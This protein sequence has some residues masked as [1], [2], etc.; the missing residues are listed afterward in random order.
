MDPA[1]AAPPHPPQAPAAPGSPTA[2]E[3]YEHLLRT[4][5]R[6]RTDLASRLGLSG[7]TLTR[8]TREMLD[9]GLLRE[10]PP[11]PQTKGRPQLP[12]DVDEHHALFV[13]LK[14]TATEVHAV[15]VDVRGRSLEELSAPLRDTA[16]A[17]VIP[18]AADL[19][20]ALVDSHPRIAGIGAAGPVLVDDEGEVLEARLLGW[21]GPVPLREELQARLGLPVT[22]SNDFHALLEGLIWFGAGRRYPSFVLLTIGAG[23]AVG[24][25][26]GGTVHRGGS[27]RAGLL[28]TLPTIAR[29]GRGVMLADVASARDVVAAARRRG[30]AGLP[31]EQEGAAQDEVEAQGLQ[32]VIAA[33]RAGDPAAGEVAA[34]VAHAVGVVAAGLVGLLDPDAVLLGGEGVALLQHGEELRTTLDGLLAP[35]HR[36]V[37]L[38][39][40]PDDFDDWTRGA[41]VIALQRFIAGS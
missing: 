28:G 1:D 16:P 6:A 33:A 4:G 2:A 22:V 37:E 14:I 32:R 38:R 35:V 12:L 8:L 10:L 36:D 26:R 27:H 20:G 18:V 25:V 11:R 3:I 24:H 21:P 15:V 19:A 40:L 30:L 17:T 13:G 29:D 31:P 39:F 9:Q 23:V 41:A 34:D 5:P 7:P